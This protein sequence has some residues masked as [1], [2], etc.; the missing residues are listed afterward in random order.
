[1]T[2]PEK[3]KKKRSMKDLIE[4]A[5]AK[6]IQIRNEDITLADCLKIDTPGPR[7]GERERP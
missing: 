7:S 5:K 2:E 6:G 3:P 1:M 4:A